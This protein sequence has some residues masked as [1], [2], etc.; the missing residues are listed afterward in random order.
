M[1]LLVVGIDGLSLRDC[2]ELKAAFPTLRWGTLENP[3]YTL[4]SCAS[5]LTGLP[6]EQHEVTPNGYRNNHSTHETSQAIRQQPTYLTKQLSPYRVGL[7]GVPCTCPPHPIDGW[8]VGGILTP[9]GSVAVWP[10]QHNWKIKHPGV[11][12]GWTLPAYLQGDK[13]GVDNA[14]YM[15]KAEPVDVL[16]HYFSG[17]NRAYSTREWRGQIMEQTVA[18]IRA[19]LAFDAEPPPIL[20]WSDHGNTELPSEYG[21]D[22]TTHEPT[23]V[24]ATNTDVPLPQHVWELPALIKKY[25]VSVEQRIWDRITARHRK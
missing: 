10:H 22:A 6:P 3:A 25:L 14:L 11:P 24:V 7:C 20:L 2:G 18:G 21:P 9:H 4:P 23:G 19:L 12:R 17:W 15:L 5:F 13:D 16:V 1:I 8:I